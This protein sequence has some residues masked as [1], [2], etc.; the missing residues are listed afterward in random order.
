MRKSEKHKRDRLEEGWLIDKEG[1]LIT[2]EKKETD[3]IADLWIILVTAMALLI[4]A[5][6]TALLDQKVSAAE[7]APVQLFI[8]ENRTQIPVQYRNYCDEIGARYHISPEMLEAIIEQESGGQPHVENGGCIGLMQ[9]YQKYHYDR[10]QLLGVAD[11]HRPYE[12]ILIATDYLAQLFDE[13][14]DMPM[15]LMIYN[16]SKDAEY[17]YVTGCYTDYANQIMRRTQELEYLHGKR[18][19][20]G[21]RKE[22]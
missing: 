1:W 9:V 21:W 10:M 13:Y 8:E 18:D 4:I 5:A 7:V 12:N 16:G 17:R 19:Y 22:L 14:E 3:K 15:V 2:D 11:L 20:E 6:V